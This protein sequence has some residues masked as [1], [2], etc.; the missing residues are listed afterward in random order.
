[1]NALDSQLNSPRGRAFQSFSNRL[2]ADTAEGAQLRA[3][4]DDPNSFD[5]GEGQ[6]FYECL[7]EAVA[8]TTSSNHNDK[9]LFADY[10]AWSGRVKQ[11]LPEV[12]DLCRAYTK[13]KKNISRKRLNLANTLHLNPQSD[14]TREHAEQIFEKMKTIVLDEETLQQ[15]AYPPKDFW[16]VESEAIRHRWERHLDERIPADSRRKEKPVMMVDPEK[17][18]HDLGPEES[19]MFV[20]KQGELQFLVLRDFCGSKEVREWCDIVIRQHVDVKRNVRKEDPGS[21]VLTGFSAGARSARSFGWVRNLVRKH[22]V[23]STL[24]QDGCSA[25]AIFWNMARGILGNHPKA[26]QIIADTENFIMKEDLYRNDRQA[27]EG[28]RGGQYWADVGDGE[29][30]LFNNAE[31]APPSGA[32]AVNYTRC[33]H[34]ERQPHKFVLSWTTSRD[35]SIE[36][37][38]HFYNCRLRT[39]V[40]AARNTLVVHIP[41]EEHGTSLQD[42]DPKDPEPEEVNQAGMSIFTSSALPGV[43][44]KFINGLITCEEAQEMA[45]ADVE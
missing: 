42:V 30:I 45:F 16:M 37:G 43:F 11:A 1:M 12:A 14:K 23:T 18:N 39:R 19:A 3:C 10:L 35:G 5:L 33:V 28:G 36:R 7:H 4:L 31:L 21:V 41:E 24:E 44:R 2:V 8:E 25:N 13:N 34:T 20:N 17:L 26:S 29:P 6:H 32:F 9:R 38:G 22:G 15:S 40:Q 27:W